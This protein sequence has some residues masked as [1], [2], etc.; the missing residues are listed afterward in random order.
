MLIRKLI[1]LN[2]PDF[3]VLFS[4]GSR[5]VPFSYVSVNLLSHS[6]RYACL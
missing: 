4:I 1:M 5:G 3:G 6:F 2:S